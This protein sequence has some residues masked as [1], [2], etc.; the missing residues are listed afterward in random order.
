MPSYIRDSSI[1]AMVGASP[2][3]LAVQRLITRIATCDASVLI[4]GET[5]TGKELAAR[6]VH[7]QSARASGPFV[8]VNCGAIPDSLLE[9][10]LF[11]HRQGAFTDAKDSSPGIL[12][13]AEGGTLL[14]DE[15]DALS[16]RAQVALLRFLQ[17]RKIRA[18]GAG[19][20]RSVD[21][22]VVAASNRKLAALA[23]VGHFRS[24]LF[25]RLNVLCVELPPLR[26]RGT[27][28]LLLA[29]R[30]LR[31]LSHRHD[32]R[33]PVIDERS[34]AWLCA[35]SW[36]G[37]V[38]ELENVIERE[39]LLSESADTLDLLQAGSMVAGEAEEQSR[40]RE[41]QN[42]R[43][44]KARTLEAFDRRFLARLMRDARGNISVAARLAGK[45]RR[46]LG[47]MLRKYEIH[48]SDFRT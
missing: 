42:Y 39:F 36:P 2:A 7:Y 6:A 4:E 38:R 29:D 44:A 40:G 43:A 5:G 3:F 15:V 34:K 35:H 9:S 22:R 8:P 28:V 10:E 41:E 24:D 1:V 23:A 18:L 27:D 47:R 14:L 25:Y 17:E 33:Q 32:R 12:A 31:D 16:A 13:L 46:E 11:G 19:Q 45:E 26:S 30:M 20:E 21:V 37:N 48:P